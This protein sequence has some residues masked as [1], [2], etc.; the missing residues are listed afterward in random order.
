MLRT[1]I[2]NG[3]YFNN[4][5]RIFRVINKK[6]L[7]DQMIQLVE[8]DC[9]VVKMSAPEV[10]KETR[11]RPTGS[12]NIPINSTRRELSEFEHVEQEELL[13]KENV[14]VVVS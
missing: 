5:W 1:S 14:G 6:L 12:S 7:L 4:M 8:G 13:K 10:H 3:M 2:Q 9:T 11:G